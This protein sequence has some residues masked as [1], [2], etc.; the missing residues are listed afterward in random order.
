ME[1]STADR[2][3]TPL[4]EDVGAKTVIEAFHKTVERHGSD[5]AIRTQG[6]AITITWADLKSRADALAGWPGQ[7]GAQARR[8]A[9]AHVP[10]PARVPP[11]RPG[12]R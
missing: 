7:A 11:R 8:H 4:E 9:R 2:A 5:V 1:S 12:R 6:D 10:Q 3:E